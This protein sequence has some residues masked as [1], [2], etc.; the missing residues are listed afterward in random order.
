MAT[1]N[2]IDALKSLGLTGLEAEIYVHLLKASPVTGYSVAKGLGKPTANVYKALDT[3]ANK[4]AVEIE[5][6]KTR[7]VRPIPYQELLHN[8]ESSFSRRRD[9]AAA[10][11]ASLPGPEQDHRIYHL[12]ALEQ[13]G[14]KCRTL[15]AGAQTI[16]VADL[17]PE[18]AELLR[19]EL[20]QL[21]KRGVK[22]VCRT[23]APFELPGADIN[24]SRHGAQIRGRWP[25]QWL[26]LVID[27]QHSLV[28]VLQ[29]GT[30]EV[31]QAFWTSSASLAYMHHSGL[32]SEIG[33][34]ALCRDIAEGNPTSEMKQSI[35]RVTAYFGPATPGYGRLLNKLGLEYDGE[36]T[37]KE[38]FDE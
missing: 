9:E 30:D 22:L 6:G 17:F 38:T 5:E 35:D 32:L 4:G 37:N 23:Y 8:L 33:F 36:T 26:N 20:E 1:R 2:P 13:V 27:G 34:S 7:Q 12:H 31:I 14:G 21:I 28:A 10:S 25:A 19:P 24:Q 29:N 11:L 3:L 15:L 16:V 18:P